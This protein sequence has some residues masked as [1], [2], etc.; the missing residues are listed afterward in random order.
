MGIPRLKFPSGS[1][2][3]FLLRWPFA[4][5]R[6][7]LRAFLADKF[8]RGLFFI[9]CACLFVFFVL[10]SFLLPSFSGLTWD[11]YYTVLVDRGADISRVSASAEKA[12]IEGLLSASTA[13]VEF[14]DFDRMESI[15]ISDLP[16]R[17]HPEDPRL[18]DFLLGAGSYFVTGSEKAHILYI[19]ARQSPFILAGKLAS[20]F[21]GLSWSI[22]EWK[23]LRSAVLAVFYIGIVAILCMR[24]RGL[25]WAAVFAAMPWIGFIMHGGLAGFTAAVLIYIGSVLFIEEARPLFEHF[26][27]YRDAG[28]DYKTLREPAAYMCLAAACA[29]FFISYSDGLFSIIPLFWGVGGTLSFTAVF[30][31]FSIW[32]R[33]R[34]E[35]R[36]FI[37][38]SI[39]PKNWRGSGKSWKRAAL[40]GV[41]CI[42]LSAPPAVKLLQERDPELVPR[43]MALAGIHGLSR[44]AL[45]DLWVLHKDSALPDFADYVGHRA[46]Q[47][48]FFYGYPKEFPSEDAKITISRFVEENES[49]RSY[50]ETIAEYNEEWYKGVLKSAKK[51]G[52]GGLL[53]RQ[54]SKGIMLGPAVTLVLDAGYFIRHCMIVTIMFLPLFFT[55]IGFAPGLTSFIRGLELRRKRQEA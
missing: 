10:T 2:S 22:V 40:A 1:S 38:I 42:I 44:E 13:R 29:F 11:G 15:S 17:L 14:S 49:I 51:S 37:P 34:V 36:L 4:V 7:L 35:H 27:Y 45:I 23:P 39:L 53:Y 50:E 31:L 26:L 9:L 43:P 21:S 16:A 3:D 8:S 18:D 20:A 19:P 52:V 24:N 30:A 5:C 41:F 33:E 47:E 25:R 46:F 28:F 48:G 12:G 32:K 54:G 55:S 6:K